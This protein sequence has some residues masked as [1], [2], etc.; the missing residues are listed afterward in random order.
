MRTLLLHLVKFSTQVLLWLF[1]V[2]LIKVQ[3]FVPT[4]LPLKKKIKK[5]HTVYQEI[6]ENF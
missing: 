6:M 4:F 2:S 1:T 5:Q 3:D